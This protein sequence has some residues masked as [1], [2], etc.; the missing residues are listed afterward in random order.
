M[1]ITLLCL[2]KKKEVIVKFILNFSWNWK[3]IFSTVLHCVTDGFVTL[4]IFIS[5]FAKSV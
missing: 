1:L 2:E 5:K 4:N 3:A